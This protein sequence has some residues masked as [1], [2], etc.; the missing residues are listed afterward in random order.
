MP[1]HVP[2]PSDEGLKKLLRVKNLDKRLDRA[3]MKPYIYMRP[4]SKL[5]LVKHNY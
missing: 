3:D 4:L 1:M 5:Y 2:V